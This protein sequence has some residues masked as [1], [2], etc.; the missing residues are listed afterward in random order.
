LIF[1]TVGT[2]RFPF[3]RLVRA[4]E[5]LEPPCPPV[6][7]QSGTSVV[8]ARHVT[9]RRFLPIEIVIRSMLDADLV[10]THAG[11]GSVLLTL[12]LGKPLI[13]VPRRREFGE[14]HDDHQVLFARRLRELDVADVVEDPRLLR[15][16]IEDCLRRKDNGPTAERSGVVA[17][18]I[19]NYL[20]TQLGPGS[21]PLE[22]NTSLGL[23][24][25]LPHLT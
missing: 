2:S 11:T 24:A 9:S 4:V 15:E 7:V 19:T 6:V 5:R 20:R 14:M 1:A 18:D 25:L 3:D 23:L 16:V 17:A 8:H 13:V 22:E 21:A 10:V 12:S